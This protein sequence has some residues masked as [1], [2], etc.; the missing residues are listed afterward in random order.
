[1]LKVAEIFSKSDIDVNVVMQ[2]LVHSQRLAVDI[3]ARET[4]ILH[5]VRTD[6]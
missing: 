3:A 6:K 1:L 4:D 5:S 2:L